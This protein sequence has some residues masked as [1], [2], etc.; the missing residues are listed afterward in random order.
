VFHDAVCDAEAKMKT[1]LSRRQLLTLF[2]MVAIA[3]CNRDQIAP[4]P[5]RQQPTESS[6]TL[7]VDGMI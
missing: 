2:G 1:Q 4:V 6:V 3:G 5:E 7:I